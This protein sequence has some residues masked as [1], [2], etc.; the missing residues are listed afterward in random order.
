MSSWQKNKLLFSVYRVI[1]NEIMMFSIIRSFFFLAC[2]I[3][4][5]GCVSSF[6][7]DNYISDF[8][9]FVERVER[10]SPKYNEKDWA[11]VDRDFQEL[12]VV[13]YTK[14]KKELTEK[15]KYEIGKLKGRYAVILMRA[16][17][18]N[19]IENAVDILD[20]A[21]GFIDGGVEKLNE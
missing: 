13:C 5:S 14:Y 15:E 16:E 4:I 8:K 6:S 21:K 1:I 18:K 10:D 20:Q 12:S 11:D 19:A 7:K 17:A 2:I 9:R 3:F